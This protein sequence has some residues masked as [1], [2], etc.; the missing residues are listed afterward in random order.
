M[1]L[2]LVMRV[3]FWASTGLL[4]YTYVG[5]PLLLFIVSGLRPRPP[6]AENMSA[7][8]SVLPHSLPHSSMARRTA[9]GIATQR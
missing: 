5:Y 1:S 7:F 6:I 2:E 9:S 4:F 3:F 8:S